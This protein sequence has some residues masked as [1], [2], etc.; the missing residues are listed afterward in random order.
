MSVQVCVWTAGAAVTCIP[1]ATLAYATSMVA[2]CK[3][4]PEYPAHYL[5]KHSRAPSWLEMHAVLRHEGTCTLRVPA[6]VM[7]SCNSSTSQESQVHF[8]KTNSRTQ[9][10]SV[11]SD[12]TSHRTLT[13]ETGCPRGPSPL[14]RCASAVVLN[15]LYYHVVP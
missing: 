13:L 3:Q 14:P 10:A 8:E 2:G 4:A 12:R 5:L 15:S 11:S 7:V 9:L 1:A 6:R